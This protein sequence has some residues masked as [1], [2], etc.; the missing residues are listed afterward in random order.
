MFNNHVPEIPRNSVLI[1]VN[2]IMQ[3]KGHIRGEEGVVVGMLVDS[4]RRK[5]DSKR[6]LTLRS[7]WRLTMGEP[8]TVYLAPGEIEKTG[9]DGEMIRCIE[10][11]PPAVFN[12]KKRGLESL[13]EDDPYR[14][15]LERY[16]K[17]ISHVDIDGDG[18]LT[19]PARFLK[20]A[21]ISGEVVL[22][23][24]F[25]RIKVWAATD[26]ADDDAIDLDD[27]KARRRAVS[28][29]RVC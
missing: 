18:R 9:C 14:I 27:F 19:I 17:Y 10:I 29:E 21:G 16:L 1:P 22:N 7:S 28:S 5:V 25:D 6:R 4:D 11:I 26:S 2:V 3:S 24:S 12:V 13:A 8:A 20:F 23:G 15:E